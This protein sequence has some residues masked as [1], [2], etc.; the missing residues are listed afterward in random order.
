MLWLIGVNHVLLI[1]DQQKRWPLPQSTAGAR[2]RGKLSGSEVEL[3]GPWMLSLTAL[4]HPASGHQ[5]IAELFSTNACW[6]KKRRFK[7]VKKKSTGFC[8]PVGISMRMVPTYFDCNIIYVVWM[9][10]WNNPCSQ[11]CMPFSFPP[12]MIFA[13]WLI[14]FYCLQVDGVKPPSLTTWP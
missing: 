1:T 13:A 9:F 4:S 12:N 11:R 14:F 10:Q 3:P 8:C 7:S 2:R 5:R 6:Q